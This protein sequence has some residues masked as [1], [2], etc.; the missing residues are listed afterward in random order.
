MKINIEEFA[1]NMGL[2]PR[3]IR[4]LYTTFFEEINTDLKLLR[5]AYENNDFDEVRGIMHNVKGVCLNL[6]LLEIGNYAKDIY[7]E[8]KEKNYSNLERFIT[9]FESEIKSLS[10]NVEEYYNQHT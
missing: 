3:D 9:Y 10:R 6:E 8:V 4:G 2:D 7:N 5:K 1:S